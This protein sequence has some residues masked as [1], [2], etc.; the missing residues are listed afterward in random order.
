MG[1]GVSGQLCRKA[2]ANREFRESRIQTAKA[3]VSIGRLARARI[4]CTS[5]TEAGMREVAEGIRFVR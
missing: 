4:D 1:G 5:G 3:T 2:R